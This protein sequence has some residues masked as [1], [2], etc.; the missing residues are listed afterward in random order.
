MAPILPDRS[1]IAP[2]DNCQD[3]VHACQR[4]D[5]PGHRRRLGGGEGD[6]RRVRRH[7]RRD[8][9]HRAP[10]SLSS[11]EEKVSCL[12]VDADGVHTAVAVIAL[13]NPGSL[14]LHESLG[15]VQAG[16]LREVG[17][18]FGHWVDTAFYH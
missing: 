10:S 14:A 17:H 16:A 8:V 3:C 1:L 12:Y 11:W 13:P 5:P 7:Q 15:F 6:L 4:R 18:K 9:R 2:S